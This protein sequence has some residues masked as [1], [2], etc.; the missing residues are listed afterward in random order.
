MHPEASFPPLS[1]GWWQ[2]QQQTQGAWLR[3]RHGAWPGVLVRWLWA[4]WRQCSQHAG[5]SLLSTAPPPPSSCPQT[6]VPLTFRPRRSAELSAWPGAAQTWAALSGHLLIREEFAWRTGLGS[7][8]AVFLAVTE[9]QL[10][11]M[12]WGLPIGPLCVD[13]PNRWLSL[14]NEEFRTLIH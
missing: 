5:L 2:Q 10:V 1:P 3:A 8:C 6:Q 12:G 13:A 4:L 14:N 9:T 7:W 11:G